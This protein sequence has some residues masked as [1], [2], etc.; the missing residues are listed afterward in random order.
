[1]HHDTVKGNP[2]TLCESAMTATV[3]VLSILQDPFDHRLF[4]IPNTIYLKMAKS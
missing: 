2:Q 4:A 3:Y 1:M